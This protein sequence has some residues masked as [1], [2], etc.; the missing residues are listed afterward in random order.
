ML[1]KIKL[2]SLPALN[3]KKPSLDLSLLEDNQ[4]DGPESEI[5]EMNINKSKNHAKKF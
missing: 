4:F 2:N 3:N 1:N 5:L